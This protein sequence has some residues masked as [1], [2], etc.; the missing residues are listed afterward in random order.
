MERTE[1]DRANDPQ[2]AQLEDD[3]NTGY[4]ADISG[5]EYGSTSLNDEESC[6][7]QSL[8]LAHCI[9]YARF[10]R[11]IPARRR[12]R[13]NKQRRC[14]YS[15]Y[16]KSRWLHQY[17]LSQ[18]ADILRTE[19]VIPDDS[20]KSITEKEQERFD[21]H[22]MV[23]R[24]I[25]TSGNH[26]G[27]G[28]AISFSMSPRILV[29]SDMPHRV[30]HANAA[31]SRRYGYSLS[32]PPQKFEA[33]HVETHRDLEVAVSSLFNPADSL[34]MYPVWG[35]EMG[36]CVTHYLVEADCSAPI[37]APARIE[38]FDNETRPWKHN[39]ATQAIA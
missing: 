31:Y 4:W 19:N 26:V 39:E 9:D 6:C 1:R 25:V 10:F 17:F 33:P 23:E 15:L 28:D 32:N 30:V 8:H 27:V 14:R 16:H 22:K 20:S 5:N 37:A 2:N 18:R 12:R 35:S 38:D 34:I 36:N 29:E 3:T 21:S 13:L 11:D 7:S 24:H